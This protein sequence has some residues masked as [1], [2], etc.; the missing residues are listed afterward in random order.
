MSTVDIVNQVGANRPTSSIGGGANAQV[1]ADALTVINT[2]PAVRSIFINIFGGITRCDEVA[3]GIVQALKLVE[4]TA[5]IVV[6]L[7]GTNATEGRAILEQH[8]SD[9]LQMMPDML[10]A[11]KTAVAIAAQ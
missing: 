2:D 10:T 7:D 3:N 9:T 8:T 4:R 11:A 5:P 6:R 1:V